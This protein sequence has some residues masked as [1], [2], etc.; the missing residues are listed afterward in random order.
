MFLRTFKRQ[1]KLLHGMVGI[2]TDYCRLMSSITLINAPTVQKQTKNTSEKIN[3]ITTEADF[4][5]KLKND[6]NKFGISLNSNDVFDEGD[7]QEEKFLME[8]TSSKKLSTKQYADIIKNHLNHGKLKEAIDVLEVKMIKEDQAKP[9]NYIY[10]LLIGGCGRNGLTKKA[11]SLFNDMKKRGLKVTG[12]TYT[13]L[14]NACANNPCKAE[15]LERAKRLRNLMVEKLYEPN[16]TNYHSMIKAFGRCGCLSTAFSIVDEMMTKRIKITA[17]TF[18]FLLHACIEDK[19]SGFRHALLVW[20]KMV[21]YHIPPSIFTYNLM[22]HTI[23]DCNLGDLEA[24]QN[25]L[26]QIINEKVKIGSESNKLIFLGTNQKLLL[27]TE[28]ELLSTENKMDLSSSGDMNYPNLMSR[29][30]KLGNLISLSEVKKPEDKLLLVGGFNAYLNNMRENNCNPDIKT[31]TL[32]LDVIPNNI[33][34]EEQLLLQMKTLKI[35]NDVDFFNMLIKKRVMRQDYEKAKDVLRLIKKYGHRPNLI[36]YGVLALCCKT[37]KEALQ[38]LDEMKNSKYRF[39][40][41]ILGALLHQACYDKNFRYIMKIMQICVDENV[42]PNLKFIEHLDKLKKDC[43]RMIK[44]KDDEVGQSAIFQRGFRLF[45]SRYSK[46]ITEIDVEKTDEKNPWQRFTE[47]T[48]INAD[49]YFVDKFR[50]SRFK[51]RRTKKSFKFTERSV[52]KNAN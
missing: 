17:D 2:H 40:A 46:W 19:E 21:K 35:R 41:E 14:F 22:L 34:A 9:E 43:R 32:L 7:L 10:N 3:S 4:L 27:S 15:G 18:N 28:N 39:N 12:G 37:E 44:N 25:V 52:N 8:R 13:A 51:P 29:I 11:F 49:K 16:D 23:R 42:Q 26:F 48:D 47:D 30:P 24:T 36:T 5:V 20:R 45:R 1:H 6:P 38:F 31:F 33:A 50:T